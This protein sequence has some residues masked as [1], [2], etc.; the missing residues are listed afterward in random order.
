MSAPGL[1]LAAP[2]SG[3]GKTL[4]TLGLLAHLARKGVK[5]ASAKVGPDY[6]DPAFH[7]AATGRPCLNLDAW[8]MRADSMAGLAGQVSASAELVIC[9]GVMGLF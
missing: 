8:A 6:I 2:S 1:I 9:E 3:S 7:A 4:A 5:V